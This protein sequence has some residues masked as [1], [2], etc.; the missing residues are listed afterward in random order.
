MWGNAVATEVA[1]ATH[2]STR[3]SIVTLAAMGVVACALADMTHEALGH[4]VVAW[5]AGVRIVSL[6]TV[7][8]QTVGTSRWVAAAGTMA[9][10]LVGALSLVI[11]NR[12]DTRKGLS[13]F[14]WVFA[15]F[16]LLNS[17]YFIASALLGNG[18]WAAV[19]G[20]L[21]PEWAWR[22]ALG[23][24]G[25]AAY[26]GSISWLARSMA[27]RVPHQFALADLPRLVTTVYLAGGAVLTTASIFNP[28]SPKLILISGVGASFVV[29]VGL[30]RVPAIVRRHMAATS[31]VACEPIPL[32]IGWLSAGIVVGIVFVAVFGPG[33]HFLV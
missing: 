7:A 25:A 18:D 32:S 26:A 16:N 20:G 8:I 22:S 15:A 29:T 4:L 10:I 2:S 9:N 1:S 30:L 27:R 11:F 6:S 31:Q 33:I 23:A 28:I 17:G 14:L 21:K 13:C 5:L 3:D 24:V 12:V 19:I